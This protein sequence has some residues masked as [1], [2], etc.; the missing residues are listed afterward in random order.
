MSHSFKTILIADAGST[1]TDWKLIV[2]QSESIAADPGVTTCRAVSP[3]INAAHSSDSVITASIREAYD[4]LAATLSSSAV[5][6]PG[7]AREI[8]SGISFIHFYGAGCRGE[9]ACDRIAKEL[10]RTF[11]EAHIEVS[12]DL[13]C[14]ARALLG[15]EPGIIAILGTGSNSALYDGESFVENTPSLGFILGDEGSGSYIGKKLLSDVLKGICP[16]I[17]CRTIMDR[18]QLKLDEV[19]AK[20]YRSDNPAAYLASYTRQLSELLNWSDSENHEERDGA[21]Y[22]ENLL[23]SA[24]EDF[25]RRNLTQYLHQDIKPEVSIVGSIAK[26]F[27]TQLEKGASR[28]GFRIKRILPSPIEGVSEYHLNEYSNEDPRY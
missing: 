28:C 26:V 23:V 18:A 3:G 9:L 13:L 12:S 1:K 22:A 24:F 2:M 4:Q 10:K 27:H 16:N 17:V 14:A 20:V 11:G 25:F 6:T 5:I 7:A 19:I 15:N 21:E 8:L